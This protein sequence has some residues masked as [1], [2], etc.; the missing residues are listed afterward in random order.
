[1]RPYGV[2]ISVSTERILAPGG[3]GQ[4]CSTRLLRTPT[5]QS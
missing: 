4:S 1:M 3:D 5:Y 2:A